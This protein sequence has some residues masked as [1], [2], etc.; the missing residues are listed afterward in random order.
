MLHLCGMKHRKVNQLRRLEYSYCLYLLEN[1][2]DIQEVYGY[3]PNR[4]LKEKSVE[5]SIIGK[6]INT[7]TGSHTL[8]NWYCQHPVEDNQCLEREGNHFRESLL[9]HND[10]ATIKFQGRLIL[11]NDGI[12]ATECCSL[13]SDVFIC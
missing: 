8:I 12:T 4:C 6:W 3:F 2:S 1:G 13:A 10:V 5:R 7:E 9:C 11:G